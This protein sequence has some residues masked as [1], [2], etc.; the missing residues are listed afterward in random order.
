ME[1]LP[2]HRD[3]SALSVDASSQ[4]SLESLALGAGTVASIA[5]AFVAILVFQLRSV[6]ISGPGSLGQYAAIA[7]AVVAFVAFVAGHYVVRTPGRPMTALDILDVL[8]AT[9][10]AVF[11]VEGVVASML[12][13]SDPHWWKMNLSALGMTDDISALAFNLTL[14][15]AGFIVTTLARY[16]TASIPRTT[17]HGVSR[18]R[19]CL[20]IV[21]VFL[22]LVGVFPVDP[23]F[24]LHTSVASGMVVA[25][26][27]LVIRL[28]AWIPGMPKAFIA[29]GWLF[30]AIV[31]VLA[32][33]FAVGFYT[34]TA[35]ELVAGILAL[36]PAG[37][38]VLADAEVRVDRVRARMLSG[39]SGDEQDALAAGLAACATALSD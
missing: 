19:T 11:L 36:T 17:P 10:L 38:D 13:A 14:I 33:L 4:R 8:L 5:S 21:G 1:T 20:I 35:V 37:V 34:L 25:Y 9:M 23:F 15:V 32:V 28:H 7:G 30:L 27:V 22:A 18:A 24:V 39:L 26:G 12:T 31:L 29:L 2:A 6:P 3:R 16:A